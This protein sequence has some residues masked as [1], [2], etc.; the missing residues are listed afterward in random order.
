MKCLQIS[1]VPV[2]CTSVMHFWHYVWK[3]DVLNIFKK[4]YWQQIEC[5]IYI[6]NNFQKP[7]STT[8]WWVFIPRPT[9]IE[10]RVFTPALASPLSLYSHS[11]LLGPGHISPPCSLS[12]CPTL[13]NSWRSIIRYNVLSPPVSHRDILEWGERADLT[14]GL[15]QRRQLSLFPPHAHS[16]QPMS[17]GHTWRHN[18]LKQ[19]PMLQLFCNSGFHIKS[20][21]DVTHVTAHGGLPG[22]DGNPNLTV[23][24]VLHTEQLILHHSYHIYWVMLETVELEAA[25]SA[26]RCFTHSLRFV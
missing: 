26:A 11:H 12:Q 20:F 25:S 22:C 6:Y 24:A 18:N 15:R 9:F 2:Y 1:D 5:N 13:S 14:E 19:E 16:L 10:L 23:A 7:F 8:L 17:D 3:S 4:I 21:E